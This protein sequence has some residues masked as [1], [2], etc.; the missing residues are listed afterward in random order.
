MQLESACV[1]L[2]ARVAAS[3][4][5]HTESH[6]RMQRPFIIAGLFGVAVAAAAAAPTYGRTQRRGRDK[7][8]DADDARNLIT[9]S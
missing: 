5:V 9:N 6:K 8:R 7:R 1:A 2:R 4:G 3:H